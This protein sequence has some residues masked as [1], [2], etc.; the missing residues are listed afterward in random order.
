MPERTKRVPLGISV[1]PEV[2]QRLAAYLDER[3]IGGSKVVEKALTQYLD[4]QAPTDV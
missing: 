1:N 2:K 3:D 4:S